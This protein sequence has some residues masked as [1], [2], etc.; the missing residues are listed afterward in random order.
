[1]QSQLDKAYEWAK[2]SYDL[3]ME[4]YGEKSR[5]TELLKAYSEVLKARILAD[6]K[7][8]TQIGSR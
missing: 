8:N 5:N 3:F 4:S 1:M 7:L 6:K 2:K